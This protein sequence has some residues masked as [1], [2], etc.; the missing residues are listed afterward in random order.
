MSSNTVGSMKT[1][2][3]NVNYEFGFTYTAVPSISCSSFI[4][5]F[6]IRAMCSSYCCFIGC[7]FKGL[8]KTSTYHSFPLT[9]EM[10]F[11]FIIQVSRIKTFK[12]VYKYD[13]SS[14]LIY[15]FAFC[16]AVSVCHHQWICSPF[17]WPKAKF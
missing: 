4:D 15:L 5:I 12:E 17:I 6:E 9:S 13:K 10:L 14:S 8:L 2:Q 3:E 1:R 7:S 16:Y 11:F